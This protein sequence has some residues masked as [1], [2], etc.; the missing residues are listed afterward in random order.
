MAAQWVAG[1]QSDCYGQWDGVVQWTTQWAADDCRRRRSG[2]MGGNLR[3]TA[4]AIMMDDGGVIPM[5][6]DSGNG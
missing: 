5:D 1:W 3:W 6:G 2:A 4:A